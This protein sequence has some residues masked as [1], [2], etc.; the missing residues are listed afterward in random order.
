LAALSPVRRSHA[1][2]CAGAISDRIA[3]GDASRSGRII[4]TFLKASIGSMPAAGD[5]K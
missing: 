1:G 2:I 3:H 5:K 4:V